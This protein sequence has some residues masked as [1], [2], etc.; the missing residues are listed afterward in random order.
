[1]KLKKAA[2]RGMIARK[3]IVVACIVNSWL[4]VCAVTRVLLGTHNWRR[5]TSAS[6]PPMT[7]KVPAETP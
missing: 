1:M 2:P 4:N 3:I 5:M 7:K 6:R